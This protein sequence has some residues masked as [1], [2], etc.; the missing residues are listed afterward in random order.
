MVVVV[1]ALL[2]KPLSGSVST[3]GSSLVSLRQSVSSLT[4]RAGRRSLDQ[5]NHAAIQLVL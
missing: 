2:T 4:A 5:V 3:P 1:V